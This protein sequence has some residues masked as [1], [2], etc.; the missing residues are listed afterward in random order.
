MVID[1]DGL[2]IL[3]SV[4]IFVVASIIIKVITKKTYIYFIKVTLAK[5][6]RLNSSPHG[7]Y[8]RADKKCDCKN[9]YYSVLFALQI[10]IGV[11]GL[12]I[13]FSGRTPASQAGNAGPIPVIRL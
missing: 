5:C 8:C 13:W 6:R 3:I 10:I 12:R 4:I 7:S 1:F 2:T 9:L 11:N